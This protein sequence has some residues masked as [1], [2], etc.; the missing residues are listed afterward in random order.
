VLREESIYE[1]AVDVLVGD[2]G[3]GGAHLEEMLGVGPQGLVHL[4]LDLGQIVASACCDHGS[5]KVV[6]E[7]PLEVLIGVD[8]VWLEAFKPS[9]RCG[10]Q[11]YQEVECFG[12][13]GSLETSMAKE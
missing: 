3:D 12:G 2:L 8:G 1:E 13:V 5:L 7:C 9:E 6:D 11:S 10:Y 4:L